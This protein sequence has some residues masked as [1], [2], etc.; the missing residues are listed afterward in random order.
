MKKHL[1]L[2]ITMSANENFYQF[3]TSYDTTPIQGGE[4]LKVEKGKGEWTARKPATQLERLGTFSQSKWN[5]QYGNNT[6]NWCATSCQVKH[7]TE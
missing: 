7:E 3:A 6:C 5:N 2:G 4:N 1:T